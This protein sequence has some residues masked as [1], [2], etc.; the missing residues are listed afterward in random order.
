VVR[1]LVDGLSS[2][3]PGFVPGSV[4]VVYVVDKVSLGQVFVRVLRF[5]PVNVI[6]PWI[7]L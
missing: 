4:D 5:F 3:R 2:R 7:L 1:R 6:P